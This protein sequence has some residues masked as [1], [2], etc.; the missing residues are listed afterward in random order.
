MAISRGVWKLAEQNLGGA[1]SARES[2]ASGVFVTGTSTEVGKTVVA[3]AL[4]RTLAGEGKGVAVFKPAVTGAEE[5]PD[6]DET[7]A[8]GATSA[9]NLPDPALLRVA[10]GSAQTDDEIAPY[11]FGPPMSPH[12]AAG[13]AG[14]EIDPERVVKA[15]RAAAA[16]TDAIVVEG[17]GGLLVPLSPTWTVRSFAVELGY[18]LVVVSPP[19]LGAIN[20]T[21]LTVESARSVGLK[22]AAIVINP[23]PAEPSTIEADNRETIAALSGIPVLTLPPLDLSIPATWPPLRLPG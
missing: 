5:F 22:V 19:G 6:Y 10:S 17:V 9:A 23:W 2:R 15:A 11:R 3:A 18:P 20:H 14:V 16:D 8:R 21:L 13:L 1:E 12:L 7:A 4:A